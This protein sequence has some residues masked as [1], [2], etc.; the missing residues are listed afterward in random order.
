[1]EMME[2]KHAGAESIEI[3]LAKLLRIG[4]VIAAALMGAGLLLSVLGV[5]GALG[6]EL[7]TIGLIVLVSTPV[8]RVAVAMAVFVRD[9]DYL[10]ALFCLVVIGA[11]GLGVLIGRTE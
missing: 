7:V 8:M 11:L 1:M 2:S 9:K 6:T 5:A 3:I 10:F 4:S